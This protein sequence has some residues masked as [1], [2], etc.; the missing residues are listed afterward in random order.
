MVALLT[1]HQFPIYDPPPLRHF[2]YTARSL[3]ITLCF[4]L[5]NSFTTVSFLEALTF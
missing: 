1:T 5:P 3:Y 2:L 4:A